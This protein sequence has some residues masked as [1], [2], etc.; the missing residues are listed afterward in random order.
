MREISNDKRLYV[1]NCAFGTSPLCAREGS[2]TSLPAKDL[3]RVEW[4]LLS[5]S[6][7]Y[8]ASTSCEPRV[9][10]TY[11]VVPHDSAGSGHCNV[12]EFEEVKY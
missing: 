4:I 8:C 12:K 9:L 6:I 5:L 3:S 2:Q 10:D 1:C 7:F 11:H